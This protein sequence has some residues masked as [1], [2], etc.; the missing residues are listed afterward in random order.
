MG[1]CSS[2]KIRTAAK[3]NLMLDVIRKR[4]DGFHEIDSLFQNISLYDEIFVSVEKKKF[5]KP[6]LSLKVQCNFEIDEKEIEDL[7][8]KNILHRVFEKVFNKIDYDFDV[9][10][11]KNIPTGAGL[12]GG[13]SNAAGFIALLEK[14]GAIDKDTAFKIAQEVGSD[15]P[16]FLYGGTAIV[17]GRGEIIESVEPLKGYFLDLI[18]PNFRIS[19]KEAYALLKPENFSKAPMSSK[20]LYD[21]YRK[22]DFKMIRKGSY[23]IFESIL[24]IDNYRALFENK[25]SVDSVSLLTGSGS[26]YFK[27]YLGV[28]RGKLKFVERG[29]EIYVEN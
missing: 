2:F 13:S 15:V 20:E 17:K 19:T 12:G 22:K 4:D 28:S 21:A 27:V 7:N 1:E 18:C 8:R 6:D 24:P 10:I 3:I 9:F 26:C 25:N 5:L 23:N 29:I 14:I 11:V 16:F